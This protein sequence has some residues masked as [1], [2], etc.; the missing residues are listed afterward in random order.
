MADTLESLEIEVK[1]NASGAD[2][3]IAKVTAQIS[4]MSKALS[5]VLP[6]LKSYAE[7]LA[8]VGGSVKKSM[9]SVKKATG[10]PLN[11]DLQKRIANASKLE[12]AYK[13]AEDARKDMNDAF[14]VGDERSAWGQ[15]AKELGAIAQAQKEI[16]KNTPKQVTPVPAAT[17]ELIG[18]A[19]EIDLLKDKI[20]S[21]NQSMRDSFANGDLDGAR[22]FRKQILQAEKS[23]AQLEAAPG[24]QAA[25]EAAAA[26][27]EEAAAKRDAAKAAKEKAAADAAAA[28]EAARVAK[29]N[30]ATPEVQESIR[31]AGPMEVMQMKLQSLRAAQD[32]AFASGDLDKA[33]ALQGQILQVSSALDKAAQSGAN[34]GNGMSQAASGVKSLSK[35]ASKSKSPLENLISSLKRIAFYRLIRSVIKAIT[36]AFSEGLQA[37]YKFSSGIEG[38]GHRFAA[39]MD[40]MASASGVMKG[41]LGAAFIGL[42][43][44]IA[45]V[46]NAI[47]AMVTRLAAA[48]SQLFGAFT[49]GTWLKATNSAEKFADTCG[50]GAAAA[51]EWKNQL[52]GFDEINRLEDPGDG[53]GGGGGGKGA[54]KV[55]F[56][57]APLTGFFARLHEKIEELKKDLDF[58]PLKEAWNKLKESLAEFA[59]FV[60]GRFWYVWDTILVPFAHWTIEE[61]LPLL[62]EDLATALDLLRT[63]LEKLDPFYQ[64]FNEFFLTPLMEWDFDR[65]SEGLK[66]IGEAMQSITDV[67]NGDIS[68]ET[69]TSKFG[70]A[71]TKVSEFANP[72]LKIGRELGEYFGTELRVIFEQ[73]AQDLSDTWESIKT[74]WSEFTEWIEEK[75]NDLK[76]WWEERVLPKWKIS[77][78]SIEIEWQEAGELMQFFG[79]SRVPKLHI[80]WSGEFATGGFP[81]DGL[82]M[83]NHGELVG[84]FSNGRTAVANNEQIIEGIKQGVIEAMTIANSGETRGGVSMAIFNVNGREFMRAVF[85]DGRAV[86]NEHGVSLITV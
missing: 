50:G 62:I 3:E 20:V 42:L 8:K 47:I 9:P 52:L 82:F 2:A 37:A 21:L 61:G 79:V 16:E 71:M 67:L 29:I 28:K 73:T 74:A 56:E 58:E 43:T 22:G 19:S 39:A 36:K 46:V 13:R 30:A 23:L 11:E 18:H 45:P 60:E 17:Q 44:A 14:N 76:T 84:Q 48:L 66:S 53:G 24:K 59:D 6:Q 27:R 54:L 64:D 15:R 55:D 40:S 4:A 34:A 57:E 69:F 10:T 49:G 63:V 68:F 51:K 33:T 7:T 41:Q 85:E 26:A 1:H 83:A 32:A 38:E 75:W 72:A 86:A 70:E 5:S 31:N 12:V 35:E 77:I 65:I 25:K 81:E 78:P 80:N